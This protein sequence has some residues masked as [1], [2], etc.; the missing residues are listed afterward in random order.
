MPIKSF[1]DRWLASVGPFAQTREFVDGACPNLR[2]R[3]GKR[4]KSFSVMIGSAASR[5]RISLGVYPT[6][7]LAEA[8][9]RAG[10][11]S[12]DPRAAGGGRPRRGGR[13]K[14]GTV[15]DLFEFVIMAMAEEGKSASI[16]DNRLYLL[17]GADAA[18]KDFGPTTLARNVTPEMATDWLA[19]F[20]E[21]QKSTRL[22]RAILSAAFNR[23]LKADNDPTSIKDRRILFGLDR[24]PVATVGGP[25]QSN[26][27]DRSLTFDEMRDFWL[28]LAD[29]SRDTP[30]TLA[31]RLIIAM[32]GVRVTEIVNSKTSWWQDE[33]GWRTMEAPRLALP[34]TKNGHPHDLPVTRAAWQLVRNAKTNLPP[35]ATYL[36]PSP[37]K[38][39]S[40]RTIDAYAK[41]VSQYLNDARVP[42]FTLRDIRRSMKNLLL[43]DDVPQVEVDIWHNHGRNADVARRNYDRAQYEH[44]KGRVRCAIDLIIE[45]L[46]E[47]LP[48]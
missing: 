15:K 48:S 19:K 31:L 18:V 8:R 46:S 27:R 14:M 34:K 36:F 24:N 33:G 21:R 37:Y 29:S 40:P 13:A 11:L 20:H 41:A 5:R 26:K 42:P 30:V 47:R 10:E 45:K 44:A 9:K 2:V 22:P 3:I 7:S 38:V 23:G 6:L 43:D 1:S 28:Y 25:T 39:K 16:K 17:E 35:D 12:A 32:G 4:R